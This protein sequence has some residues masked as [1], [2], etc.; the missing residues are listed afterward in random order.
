MLQVILSMSKF[1][2]KNRTL[3]FLRVVAIAGNVLFVIW[4][5]FNA[6]DVGWRGTPAE[7]IASLSLIFILGL[8]VFLITKKKSLI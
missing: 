4:I 5:L 3:N 1:T 6:M 2:E 7:I 8:N